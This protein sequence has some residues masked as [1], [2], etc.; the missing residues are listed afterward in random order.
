M[1]T[2][3]V[4]IVGLFAFIV[5]LSGLPAAFDFTDDDKDDQNNDFDDDANERPDRSHT[6]YIP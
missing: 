6:I 3:V 5:V 1:L 4:N 2:E